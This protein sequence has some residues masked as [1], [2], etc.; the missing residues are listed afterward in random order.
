MEQST[1]T[2]LVQQ[3]SKES[4][5]ELRSM[6][7]DE[8]IHADL[9]RMGVLSHQNQPHSVTPDPNIAVEWAFQTHVAESPWGGRDLE[10]LEL[11]E[12]AFGIVGQL[13]ALSI[14]ASWTWDP[15]AALTGVA[16]ASSASVVLAD[17][18][19]FGRD[20][21]PSHITSDVPKA[22]FHWPAAIEMS[23][24]VIVFPAWLRFYVTGKL[25]QCR[26]AHILSSEVADTLRTVP[27]PALDL[28]ALE[29]TPVSQEGETNEKALQQEL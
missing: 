23:D 11:A 14:P 25:T 27:Q 3:V 12:K 4:F 20:D 1:V 9:S 24:K 15:E 2:E 21:L 17:P 8:S 19:G 10:L 29:A 16:C 22:P 6:M 18:R 13:Q 26:A 7:S 28:H 5:D